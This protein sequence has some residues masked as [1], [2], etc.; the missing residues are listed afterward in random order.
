MVLGDWYSVTIDALLGLWH[1]FLV[2]IPAMIGAIV[3][4][5]VGWFISVGVG[6]LVT[7]ILSRLKFDALFEKTDWQ[8]AFSKA[9]LS[10]KPAEFLGAIVKWILVIVFLLIAAEILG[11][12]QFTEFLRE[13]VGYLPN[14]FIAALIFVVAILAADIIEKIVVAGIE[15]MKIRYS[16][17][18]G[19]VVK[20]AIWVFAI[21]AILYQLG[22]ARPMVYTLFSGIIAFFVIAFGLAFGLGGKDVA[23]ELLRDWKRKLEGGEGE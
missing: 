23:A 8:R 4:F 19:A 12:P 21:L 1:G 5:V 3:V 17:L 22:I 10:V 6:K 14:V 18:A 9:K 15:K 2:F 16:A 11:L 13:I 20:W 7:E